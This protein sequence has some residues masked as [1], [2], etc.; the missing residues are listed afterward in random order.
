[1]DRVKAALGFVLLGTAVWMFERV[2]P[3]PLALLMW[4]ALLLAVA[5]TLVHAA[6]AWR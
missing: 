4:G 6:L 1:M 2:V 5:V 3:A